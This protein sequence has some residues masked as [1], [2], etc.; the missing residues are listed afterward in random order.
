MFIF[1]M[2]I[3]K[4]L[5]MRFLAVLFLLVSFNSYSQYDQFSID[6][7]AYTFLD[8]NYKGAIS[9]RYDGFYMNM[10][11]EYGVYS[12]RKRGFSHDLVLMGGPSFGDLK[13]EFGLGVNYGVDEYTTNFKQYTYKGKVIHAVYNCGVRYTFENH[14]AITVKGSIPGLIQVG[15]H[16]SLYNTLRHKERR[17]RF[18]DFTSYRTLKVL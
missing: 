17:D 5:I 15:V 4:Y 7:S 11:L 9:A 1:V 13:L 16:F 18:K 6:A 2:N 12:N 3:Y 8:L 14:T 10:G